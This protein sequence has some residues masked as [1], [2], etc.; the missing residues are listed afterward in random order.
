MTKTLVTQKYL[1]SKKKGIQHIQIPDLATIIH[2]GEQ[3][4][5]LYFW[6]IMDPT[7]KI[8]ERD[9]E[10]IETNE[11]FEM[12]MS[13]KYIGIILTD[14]NMRSFHVIERCKKL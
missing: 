7:N 10:V 4:G 3:C 6:A 13:T 2:V 11:T 1:L 14:H 12:D 9:F 8:I 5:C